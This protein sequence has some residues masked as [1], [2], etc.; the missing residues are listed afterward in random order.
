MKER[1]LAWEL[2]AARPDDAAALC[3]LLDELGFP[4]PADVIAQRLAMLN[5]RGESVLVASSG[6]ELLGFV[7]VHVTPVLHRPAPVG[8]LTALVVAGRAR[9]QGIGRALVAAA[10]RHLA[11][12]GCGLVELTSN[13]KLVEAHAFYERLGYTITSH[14]FCKALPTD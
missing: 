3:G 11:S 1:R 10:E 4:S 8:R 5:Q 6:P 7:S 9:R 12:A 13:V 2:R 14:R